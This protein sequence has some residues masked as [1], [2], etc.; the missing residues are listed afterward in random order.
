MAD[1]ENAL[2]DNIKKKGENSYYYA[3]APRSFDRI[4]EA[5]VLEGEGIVTGGPPKL[6]QR[7]ESVNEINSVINLRNYSWADGDDKV[8]IYVPFQEDIDENRVT[9]NF[10]SKCLI[11]TYTPNETETRRLTLKKLYKEINPDES[12]FRIR[13]NKIIINLKKSSSGSWYKLNDN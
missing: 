13:K 11:M 7:Q 1:T 3:H 8:T 6:I 5:K 4:E 9:C 10:E 2:V 12:G